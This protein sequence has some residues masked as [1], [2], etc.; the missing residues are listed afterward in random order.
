MKTETEIRNKIRTALLEA[1]FDAIDVDSL[2]KFRESFTHANQ[3][4]IEAKKDNAGLYNVL[5]NATIQGLIQGLTLP[6]LDSAF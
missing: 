4:L 6:P 3:A 2:L 1:G 5:L